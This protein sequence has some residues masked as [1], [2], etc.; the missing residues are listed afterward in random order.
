MHL[1]NEKI[2]YFKDLVKSINKQ[3]S[4]KD[5]VYLFGCHTNSQMLVYFNLNIKNIR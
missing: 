5:S 2:I 1:F 4:D 3:I